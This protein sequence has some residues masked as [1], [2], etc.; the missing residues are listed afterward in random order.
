[1]DYARASERTEREYQTRRRNYNGGEREGGQKEGRTG[2]RGGGVQK[3]IYLY[4]EIGMMAPKSERGGIRGR[5]IG[6]ETNAA[7]IRALVEKRREGEN[8]GVRSRKHRARQE[9]RRQGVREGE[10]G[11]KGT[12]RVKGAIKRGTYRGCVRVR[13]RRTRDRIRYTRADGGIETSNA[14]TTREIGRN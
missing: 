3:C 6:S 1:M 11:G 7:L 12:R 5:L 4:C 9:V 14:Q 13:K 8:A 10:K 2:W